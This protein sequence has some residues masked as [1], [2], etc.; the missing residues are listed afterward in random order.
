MHL[1]YTGLFTNIENLTL[2]SATDERY[3]RGGGTEFDYNL[4]L[5]DA[6]VGAG[7]TL[8]VSG[9]LLTA[10]ESMV[11]DGSLETNGTLRLFGGAAVDTLKGGAL[12]DLIH[13]NMAGDIL[14]GGGGADVFATI[15]RPNRASARRPDHRLHTG[16]RQDRPQPDRRH[17]SAG[18][19]AFSMDRLGRV[20]RLGRAAQGLGLHGLHLILEG[21]NDGNGSPDL[22]LVL[23][24]QGRPRSG[25]GLLPLA[26]APVALAKAK[27]PALCHLLSRNAGAAA[28]RDCG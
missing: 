18:D 4:T 14:T 21:D 6:I 1:C 9:T 19:Q 20:H 12:A 7:Q 3:A 28:G 17:S 5:S 15:R 25:R 10:T 2:T 27:S 13:G 26:S 24:L 8:T 22:F 23:T 11:L 16:H